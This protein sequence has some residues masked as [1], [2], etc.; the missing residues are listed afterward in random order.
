MLAAI[1]SLVSRHHAG[2]M[3][4]AAPSLGRG[5]RHLAEAFEH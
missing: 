4:H 3:A 5:R 1:S 2:E